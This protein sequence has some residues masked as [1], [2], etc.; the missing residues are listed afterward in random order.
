MTVTAPGFGAYV[1]KDLDLKVGQELNLNISLAIS[2]S[3]TIVDLS[4]TPAMIE[5]TKTDVSQVIDSRLIVDLP[6]NGRRVD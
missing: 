3:V 6:I 1:A 5:D 4:A 2:P